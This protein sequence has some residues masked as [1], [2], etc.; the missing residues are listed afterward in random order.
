MGSQIISYCRDHWKAR[1]RT[2]VRP[3]SP[4]VPEGM[5]WCRSCETAQ[6]EA[7][8]HL[9]GT[10]GRLVH[11]CKTCKL[12]KAAE[13]AKDPEVHA[14]LNEGARRSQIKQKYGL[15]HEAFLALLA[16]QDGRCG[17]CRKELDP[18]VLRSIHVDHDHSCCPTVR[19][20]G[21]CVR[22]LLCGTCNA[23]LHAGV[24]LKWVLQVVAYLDLDNPSL[25]LQ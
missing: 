13:R 6:P 2:D 8:F 5:W 9:R 12:V 3:T 10:T 4:D 23:R 24:D 17:V 14:R 15:D 18:T 16:K 19:T 7:N 22:G 20:C 21:K 11:T 1:I 25:Y